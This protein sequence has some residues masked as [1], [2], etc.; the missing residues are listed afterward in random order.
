VAAAAYIRVSTGSQSLASQRDA[1]GRAAAQRGDR[2][3]PQHWFS[4]SAS[5]ATLA[6]PALLRLREGVRGGKFSRVYV[7]RLDRLSRGG[8][9]QTFEVCDE[10][11]RCG[12]ELVSVA[13]GFALDGPA[14][15]VVL[16]VLA[17]AA[18]MER[19]AIGERIAATHKQVK[20][21][22]GRWGRPGRID[23]ATLRK[24]LAMEKAGRTQREIAIALKIPR[25]TLQA[26]LAGR[27]HYR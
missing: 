22:G 11:K 3:A 9:R 23:A 13:D 16:A 20:A 5:S 14:S 2:I 4:E 15:E 25:S 12:V 21:A 1:V 10:F 24:A 26:A 27:G 7:F 17:W 6:R 19:L 8:I 18:Q